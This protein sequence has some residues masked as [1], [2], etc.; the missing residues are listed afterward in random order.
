M[1]HDVRYALRMM[2]ANPLFTAMAILSLALGIGANTAIYSFMDAILMRSLPVQDPQSLVVFK[3]HSTSN[4]AVIHSISGS[5]E[6]DPKTGTTSP[7][8]PFAAFES[9]GSNN[10]AFSMVFAYSGFYPLTALIH[11]QGTLVN[12]MYVSGGFFSGLGVPPAAGRLI[13]FDDD[14]AGA[15]AIAIVSY[16]FAQRRFGDAEKALGQTATINDAPFTIAGVAAPGFHGV[17]PGEAPDIYLP[18]HANLLVDRGN[19]LDPASKYSDPNYYWIEIMGR[20]RPGVTIEQASAVLAHP[21]QQL[22]ASAATT[23]KERADLPALLLQPGGRGLDGLRRRYSKPLYVLMTMVALILTI[24][25]AN[26]ANLLLARAAARR[27]EMAVRLSLGAGR[28]RVVRQL[29]TESILLA[30]IGGALGLAFAYWGIRG[31]GVLLANGR[32]D[33]ALNVTMNWHVLA[34]TLGLALCTGVLFGLAPALQ[35]TRVD[36][37]TALKQTRAGELRW[38]VRSWLRVSLSQALVVSQIAISLLLLVGAGLFVRTLSN[39]GSV[40]L[41]FNRERVLLFTVN[42]RQAGYRDDAL[43]RFYDTLRARL[44]AIP[45]VRSVTA[46]NMALVSQGMISYTVTVP[47]YTGTSRTVAVLMVAPSFFSTMQIPVLLGREIGQRDIGSTA[48]IAVVNEVFAKTYFAGQNPIGRRFSTGRGPNQPEIEIVGV[49]KTARYNS[50]KNDIPPVAYMPYS[51]NAR[52][53]AQL[54]FELRA[55]GDPLGLANAAREVL[56]QADPRIPVSKVITQAAQIDQTVGQERTFAMLCTCFAV[57]AVL[58]ACV[59]LYGT[60][61]YSV[62]RRT[63]ELGLRMALGAQRPRLVWMVMREVFAMA[64]VGLAIGLPVAFA[65]TKFV[66]AF[67]FG[68]KPN[69][70]WALAGA[71]VVLLIAAAV[72]GYGP[73]WRASRIDPWNALRDE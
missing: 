71:A 12:G 70:P 46:S 44:G 57:L 49:S 31:L 56:R 73:A 35:S 54:T 6:S 61:A 26:L 39:L 14:R 72:A 38:R 37:T 63:N 3:W 9:L 25:C 60:M 27:R 52:A 47:G 65:T 11:Q 53:L 62:A 8:F 5:W 22:I 59:G 29:L 20:L 68:M 58:I 48:S 23:D 17:D 40:E 45:G 66:K 16:G 19:R 36:L 24:A 41:G 51:Q 42:A 13:G 4:P 10:P 7:N 55:A 28:L 1:L 64:A 67:L 15:P 34:V 32:Q 18:L 33:F 30:A 69:N 21:F 50:L 2:R 43:V